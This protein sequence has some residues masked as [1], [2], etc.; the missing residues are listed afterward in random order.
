MSRNL[1][2]FYTTALGISIALAAWAW[3]IDH[4]HAMTTCLKRHSAGTCIHT[5]R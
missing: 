3:A 4:R 1:C 2:I 5:L